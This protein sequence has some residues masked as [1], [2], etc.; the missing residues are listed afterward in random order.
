MNVRNVL[1]C[2]LLAAAG[3]PAAEKRPVEYVDPRIDT[4]QT[5]WI[6][7]ASASRP[8][9]MVALS[10]D[11]KLEGD[12]GAGY[13]YVE[14][15][16]RAFSHIHDW[17]LAGVPVMPIVGRMNGHEGYEAY[18]APFS[19][20]KETVR[21]GYHKVVLDNS[22]I[23]AELTSTRRVGF[24]R[25]SFPATED[26]YVL[27]DTG[28]PIAMTKMADATLRRTGPQQLSGFSKM[29]P[30]QRREK[31]CTVYFVAE[32]DQPFTEFGGWEKGAAGKAV[33]QGVD[34]VSG[35]DSGGYVRFRFAQPG[36]VR[37]KVAISYVSEENARLNLQSELPGWDFD[38][39]VKASAGEWN[40]WLGKIQVSGG[41][42]QQRVKFYTD[43]WH[44]LLGRR[45]FSDVD[46]RY[47]DNTGAEPRVRQVPLDAQ[48]Q[49]TRPTFNSD[50]FWGSH[51]N[52][53]VLWS[54]AYPRIMG[55][56]VASLV[57]Y[58]NNGGLIARGPAGG[59]YT[60]VMIGDQAV[61]LI[62]AAYNKGIRDFDVE[63]AYA[64]SRKNAFP[65]G[66]RDRAGYEFGP[67]PTGGGMPFYVERGWIP[68]TPGTRGM[69]RAGAAQTLEY[70]YEDWCLA[71]FAKALGKKDDY[72]L[73]S[74]RAENWKNLYD[75]SVG[76]I[77]PRN[78]DG[79]WLTPFTPTCQGAA[80]PGFVES[81]S[82]IYTYFVPQDIPGLVQ[83]IGGPQ[84][85]IDKLNHQFELAAP[86]RYVTPHGTHAQEWVDYENQ[87]SCHMAHLF[88]YAGA[89][90]L[91]QYWV[92]RVKEESYGGI[93]PFAGYNGDEDQGQMG[94]L[95]VLMAMGLFDVTGGAGTEP[96][97]ELTSPIFD[98]ID[99]TLDPRYAKGKTFT[100]TTRNNESG[101]VY[102]QSVKLNGKALT[103]RFWIT[104][105]ELTA[106]G[107]LEVTLGP[108]PNKQW[109]V[110]AR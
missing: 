99:V 19:H 48:G 42:E 67:N 5:R 3:L 18:K 47:I 101:N 94:A 41:T 46:G 51:W 52:L 109:G 85:F 31:P 28:A 91:T 69:H 23:T 36:Q 35:A 83:A 78:P 16:I 61:P 33:K 103:G 62:V 84:K 9:G 98:R 11:T 27:L 56:Q 38:A 10:P 40:E 105:Q 26:A 53:N 1:L 21:A 20:E 93:T 6:F 12:W 97:Y 60:Y 88:T 104:H 70:A 63:A 7:F 95:G 89:P 57:D 44:A 82:A 49:P 66:I 39:T 25:Y 92:R 14:P 102:I 58:Y 43:L 65:G 79:S 55:Q 107:T 72:A 24:H 15:Y 73:F 22:G 59:N 74:R 86:K 2:A 80:C 45:T 75:P 13:I 106:G 96:R 100:I 108:Q 8:F 29:A 71:Q 34:Q 68:A 54:F 64:G 17:Q 37:M 50:G 30:T 32:F 76:W 110:P 87:P 77:R 4:H 90:W 81:N